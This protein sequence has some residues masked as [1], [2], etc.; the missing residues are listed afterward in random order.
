[1]KTR[2]VIMR[3]KNPSNGKQAVKLVK[4]VI[5]D[6]GKTRVSATARDSLYTEV[7]V[8]RGELVHI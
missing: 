5:G 2:L 7:G 1:M 6:D 8:K 4:G 3:V